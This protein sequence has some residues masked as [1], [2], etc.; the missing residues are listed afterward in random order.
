MI[1][2]TPIRV[3]MENNIKITQVAIGVLYYQ[4]LYLLGYRSANQ[5]QGNKYEF[6]GGKIEA[7]ETAKQ[8]LIREVAEEVGLDVSDSQIDKLGII[9]HE[10]AT[11]TVKLH[12]FHVQ[13][14]DVQYSQFSN[15]EVG[16]E[17][18][19]VYWVS[20][21][22]LMAGDYPLPDANKQ[23]LQWLAKLAR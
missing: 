1:H 2:N 16:Q 9:T 21:A 6:V 4:N 17:Q 10:Y 11:K 20:K 13:I 3:N 18:Q 15:I 5:H 14:D 7:N 23:I 19:P 8:A 22:N 12:V